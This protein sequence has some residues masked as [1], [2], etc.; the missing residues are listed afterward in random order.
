M[1]ED[2][3]HWGLYTLGPFQEK[4]QAP[5]K[6]TL[7]ELL[8]SFTPTYRE[9]GFRPEIAYHYTGFDN[10]N[11]LAPSR[12]MPR[13]KVQPHYF[14]QLIVKYDHDRICQILES[15]AF[16]YYT[17]IEY[18]VFEMYTPDPHRNADSE[19]F[20]RIKRD[21]DDVNINFLWHT[22]NRIDRADPSKR[23]TESRYFCSITG[24]I[25]K[26][27]YACNI[28]EKKNIFRPE[29]QNILP[30]SSEEFILKKDGGEKYLRLHIHE[31]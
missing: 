11:W 4:T 3:T 6:L 5:D 27:L 2:L 19:K 8:S 29:A 20:S 21:F 1:S 26:V 15:V 28:F 30:L 31:E 9:N 18:A 16:R 13:G 14:S 17:S 22:W 10:G 25:S 7:R 12:D 24:P 23:N